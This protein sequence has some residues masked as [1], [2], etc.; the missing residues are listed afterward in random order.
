LLASLRQSEGLNAHALGRAGVDIWPQS[1]KCEL[2]SATKFCGMARHPLPQKV[3]IMNLGRPAIIWAATIVAVLLLVVLLRAILLPFVAAIALAYLLDPVVDWLHRFGVNRTFAAFAMLATFLAA[4]GGI[5]VLAVPIIGA[6][7][8]DF[9]EKVPGYIAQL[10]ALAADP[11]RP[12]L[13]KVVGAGLSEAEQSAGEI[14]TFAADWIPSLL[15]SVWSDS[16]AVISLFS[17]LVVTPIVTF[18][19]LKDWKRVIETINRS[20]PEAQRGTV[21]ELA[22]ELDDTISGFL[23]GQGTICL[24]LACYYGLALHLIKLNHGVLIGLFAGL[25]SFIPYLGSFAGLL[26]S[27]CVALLQFWPSWTEIPIILAIFISG[28]AIA[29]YAL[30]PYLIASRVHLNP[31]W[32]MFAIAAFGYLFGFVGLILA[33]P[34]AAAIGVVIRF[35]AKHYVEA[36]PGVTAPLVPPSPQQDVPA[37][38]RNW[39]KG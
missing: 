14:A 9:I 28:Q 5:G 36:S 19:L 31:V 23:R 34:L 3:R 13:R 27:I 2:Q 32:V 39:L 6:E 18:Y 20:I 24:V 15:R 21:Q 8:A 33:V 1:A 26:L 16:Q 38:R 17:L 25:I 22:K 12:W 37:P 11:A 29:D 4:V 35:A 10:Q 7:I 30:A